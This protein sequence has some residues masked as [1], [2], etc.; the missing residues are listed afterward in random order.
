M[1]WQSKNDNKKIVRNRE[2]KISDP[3]LKTVEKQTNKQKLLKTRHSLTAKRAPVYS[4]RAETRAQTVAW[5][6]PPRLGTCTLDDSSHLP[7]CSRL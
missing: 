2:P 6:P 3:A 5:L 4:L 1:E 7:L